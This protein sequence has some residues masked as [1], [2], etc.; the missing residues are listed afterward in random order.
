M[1]PDCSGII[2]DLF[3]EV[4]IFLSNNGYESITEAI[5]EY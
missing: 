4:S 5:Y 1:I 3:F 2:H